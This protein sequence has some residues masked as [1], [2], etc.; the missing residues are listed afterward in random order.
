MSWGSSTFWSGQGGPMVWHFRM[1]SLVWI[2]PLKMHFTMFSTNL[3]TPDL[4]QLSCTHAFLGKMH[5]D[6]LVVHW[7][8]YSKTL[9]GTSTEHCS[10][11]EVSKKQSEGTSEETGGAS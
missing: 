11:C 6:G 1:W 4:S 8:M 7:V 10:P 9:A 3:L 5:L 2:S